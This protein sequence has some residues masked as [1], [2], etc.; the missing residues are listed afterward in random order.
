MTINLGFYTE[1]FNALKTVPLSV[2]SIA[3]NGNYTLEI[4][5]VK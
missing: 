4:L 1:L 2:K 3:D 5:T